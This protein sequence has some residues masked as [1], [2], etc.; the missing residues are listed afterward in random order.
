LKG[1]SRDHLVQLPDHFRAKQILKYVIEGI[2]QIPLEH[3]QALGI[4]HLTRKPVPVYYTA[5]GSNTHTPPTFALS[6]V[7][8]QNTSQDLLVTLKVQLY[9]TM[10]LRDRNLNPTSLLSPL[11]NTIPLHIH[12]E[13]LSA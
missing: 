9:A 11:S 10:F 8:H 7:S 13:Y 4:N 12:H 2:V 6:A 5:E 1:T 3:G